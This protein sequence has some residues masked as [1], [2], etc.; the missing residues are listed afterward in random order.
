V[1]SD[2]GKRGGDPGGDPAMVA[3][4][5]SYLFD[6]N[7]VHMNDL[8]FRRGARKEEF[9]TKARVPGKRFGGT[10]SNTPCLHGPRAVRAGRDLREAA[11]LP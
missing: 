1:S 5:A 10:D 9:W 6:G 7:S 4:V 8:L 2:P 3:L 11:E